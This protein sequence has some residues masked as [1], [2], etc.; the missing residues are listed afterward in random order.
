MALPENALPWEVK[1]AKASSAISK[2]EDQFITKFGVPANLED[3]VSYA[4]LFQTCNLEDLASSLNPPDCIQGARVDRDDLAQALIRRHV[5]R[6]PYVSGESGEVGCLFVDSFVQRIRYNPPPE[7]RAFRLQQLNLLL[8]LETET[9][10]MAK[11]PQLTQTLAR[12]QDAAAL[13]DLFDAASGRK[14]Y[15]SENLCYVEPPGWATSLGLTFEQVGTL[16]ENGPLQ[17]VHNA[18][19]IRSTGDSIRFILEAGSINYL[20][21]YLARFLPS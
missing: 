16:S 15:D 9:S 7:A 5:A 11:L 2:I 6:Q 17:I 1:Y 20:R 19:A 21:D 4:K 18:G 12:I 3:P 10:I 14:Q 13:K 8:E